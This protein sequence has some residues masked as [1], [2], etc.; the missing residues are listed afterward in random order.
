VAVVIGVISACDVEVVTQCQVLVLAGVAPPAAL[1]GNCVRGLLQ[2]TLQMTRIRDRPEIIAN[3]VEEMLR[4]DPPV[5]AALRI[6]HQDM[7]VGGCPV[8][9][10]ETL[11]AALAA[12]NRDPTAYPNADRLD[13]FRLD[14]HHHTFGGGNH[15]CLGDELVRA[16]TQE[17]IRTFVVCFE[18]LEPSKLGW[19]FAPRRNLRVMKHLWVRA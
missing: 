6:A 8:A 7:A 2:N 3:A 10:G 4:F 13:V 5:I 12:A 14:T 18:D 15:A 17:A 9:K 11:W 19:T 1:L 16:V